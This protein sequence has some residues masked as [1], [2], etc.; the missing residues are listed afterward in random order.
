MKNPFKTIRSYFYYWQRVYHKL[1]LMNH[2][3]FKSNNERFMQYLSNRIDL[4]NKDPFYWT[5]E[6]VLHHL[7]KK[8]KE[9]ACRK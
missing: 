7:N 2:I 6:Y 3:L 5:D 8:D 1:G 9:F 4:K